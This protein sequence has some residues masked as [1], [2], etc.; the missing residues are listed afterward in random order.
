MTITRGE[1]ADR[2]HRTDPT[3]TQVNMCE[4]STLDSILLRIKIK[5]HSS[6]EIEYFVETNF[7]CTISPCESSGL[8]TTTINSQNT[9]IAGRRYPQQDRSVDYEDGAV[10]RLFPRRAL[11]WGQNVLSELVSGP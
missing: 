1:I 2:A 9:T 10:R 6:C 11:P 5:I 7:S 4:I 8:A 3:Q